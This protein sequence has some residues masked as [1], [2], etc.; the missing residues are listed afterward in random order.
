MSVLGVT[1]YD[2]SFATTPA[3]TGTKMRVATRTAS[4]N[5]AGSGDTASFSSGALNYASQN[6][7]ATDKI[8]LSSVS[9]V[10]VDNQN[11]NA[12]TKISFNNATGALTWETSAG[13]KTLNLS[14]FANTLKDDV[15][16]KNNGT[17]IEVYNLTTQEKTTLNANGTLQKDSAGKVVVEKGS[18]T[19]S[20]LSVALYINNQG[21]ARSTS[22]DNDVIINR[23]AGQDINANGGNDKIFNMA[24]GAS[25]L[26]GG[27]GDDAI[28]SV[29]LTGDAAGID[30]S[31]GN[32][33]VKLIGGI[34]KSGTV[35]YPR[36]SRGLENV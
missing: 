30:V 6:V 17:D 33:Y 23:E 11:G 20:D 18:W 29:G 26:A 10:L 32:G 22:N 16:I 25:K 27:S 19:A 21:K 4:D 15:V 3:A 35:M 7:A 2:K 14:G 1:T 28:Y 5:D 9:A 13:A 8:T 31:G 12:E 24:A 36:Q 34:S